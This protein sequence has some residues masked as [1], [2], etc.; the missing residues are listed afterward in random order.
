MNFDAI[1]PGDVARVAEKSK[2]KN[3]DAGEIYAQKPY[4][5]S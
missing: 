5:D 3:L 2:N 1:A 4:Y